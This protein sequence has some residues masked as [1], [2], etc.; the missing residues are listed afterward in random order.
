[1]ESGPVKKALGFLILIVGVIGL[2]YMLSPI[3]SADAIIYAILLVL[4]VLGY[5][6]AMH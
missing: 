1:M 6:W 4:I 5:E 2:T 3:Y